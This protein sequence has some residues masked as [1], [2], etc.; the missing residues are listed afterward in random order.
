MDRALKM[1]RFKKES[2]F[3]EAGELGELVLLS[4][5]LSSQKR[6]E[7]ERPHEIAVIS[8]SNVMGGMA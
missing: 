2:I 3:G 1:L 4:P 6:E 7:R 5:T 8:N